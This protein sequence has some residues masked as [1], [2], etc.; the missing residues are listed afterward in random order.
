V[1]LGEAPVESTLPPDR[2]G[3]GV[4]KEN[5]E[6]EVYNLESTGL[7]PRDFPYLNL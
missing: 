4:L 2:R 7:T 1:W 6:S 3:D 5:L